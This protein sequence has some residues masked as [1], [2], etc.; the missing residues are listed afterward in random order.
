MS[1]PPRTV[2]YEPHGGLQML[3]SLPGLA[4]A[5]GL[6]GPLPNPAL[7]CPYLSSVGLQDIA[8]E[9]DIL[10]G[11]MKDLG[12]SG[13]DPKLG[14][15]KSVANII[16]TLAFGRRFKEDDPGFNMIMAILSSGPFDHDSLGMRLMTSYAGIILRMIPVSL[17]A[18]ADP[19]VD[20]FLRSAT[21][22]SPHQISYR[23]SRHYMVPDAF[24]MHTEPCD[25]VV[26]APSGSK[27]LS[28]RRSKSTRSLWTPTIPDRS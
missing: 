5:V 6:S 3:G 8:F 4:K 25:R 26:T 23:R 13:W 2:A 16:A 21:P 10:V 11:K 12:G 24:S 7:N 20:V 17:L 27:I 1:S 22:S 28:P 19:L 18:A 14:I 15:Q 9:A